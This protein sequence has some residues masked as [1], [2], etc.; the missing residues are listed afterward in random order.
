MQ[1]QIEAELGKTVDGLE[2]EM[3]EQIGGM[4]YTRSMPEKG[5]PKDKVLEQIR[6]CMDLGKENAFLRACQLNLKLLL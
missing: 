5:L 3:R 4:K 1:R 6:K 2:K